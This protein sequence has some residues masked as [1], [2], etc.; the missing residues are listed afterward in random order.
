MAG[1]I[2]LAG[3]AYRVCRV[4][5]D[6]S[7]LKDGKWL[8]PIP[9]QAIMALNRSISGSLSYGTSFD[10][11]MSVTVYMFDGGTQLDGTGTAYGLFIGTGLK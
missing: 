5:L 8:V 11:G 9:A 4:Q 1:D 6:R 7:N 3:G 10:H 2:A